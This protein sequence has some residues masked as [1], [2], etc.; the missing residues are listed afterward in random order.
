VLKR[1]KRRIDHVEQGS[2]RLC[3]LVALGIDGDGVDAF[4]EPPDNGGGLLA[5]SQWAEDAEPFRHH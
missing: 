2:G 1:R 5:L 3:N 4:P